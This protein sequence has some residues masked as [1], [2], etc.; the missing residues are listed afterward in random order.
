[1]WVDHYDVCGGPAAPCEALENAG[2]RARLA[3]AGGSNNRRMAD[4]E[5]AGV[6]AQRNL[7]SRGQPSQTQMILP[8]RRKDGQKILRGCEMHRVIQAWIGADASLK[9]MGCSVNLA[10]Q[11]DLQPALASLYHVRWSLYPR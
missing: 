11:L 6:Q 5:P 7:I 4:H 10:Q 2:N 8:I 9:A 3:C 1:M